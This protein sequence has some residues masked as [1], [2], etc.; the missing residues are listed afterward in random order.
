VFKEAPAK[1]VIG[2]SRD[3]VLLYYGCKKAIIGKGQRFDKP[4]I[5]YTV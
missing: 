3:S 1:S 5:V 4:I 2:Y